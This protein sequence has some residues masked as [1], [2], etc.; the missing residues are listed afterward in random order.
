[1]AK[2]L[3]ARQGQ[4]VIVLWGEKAAPADV[5]VEMLIQLVISLDAAVIMAAVAVAAEAINSRRSMGNLPFGR[6]R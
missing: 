5:M 3:M 6:R 1:M 4:V 2:D